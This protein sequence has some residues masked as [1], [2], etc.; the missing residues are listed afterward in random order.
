MAEQL[1]EIQYNGNYRPN[2]LTKLKILSK[3]YNLWIRT[4]WMDKIISKNVWTW[5]QTG[6]NS[7]KQVLEL[8]ARLTN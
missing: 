8:G 7:S 6:C 4:I 2:R 5:G 3:K 1:E